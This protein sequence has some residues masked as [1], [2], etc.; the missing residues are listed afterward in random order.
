[1]CTA[2]LD[3]CLI[4]THAEDVV[5]ASSGGRQGLFLYAEHAWGKPSNNTMLE[6][7]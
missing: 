1:L 5:L 2:G 3:V 4:A 7:K 6:K